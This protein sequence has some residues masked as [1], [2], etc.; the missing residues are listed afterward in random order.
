MKPLK[1]TVTFSG[2]D[3]PSIRHLRPQVL[4]VN[5]SAIRAKAGLL[6]GPFAASIGVPKGTLMNWEQGRR[7][8]TGA[9]KVLLAL[10]AKK[11]SLVAD[12]YPTPRQIP[13]WAAG[14]PDPSKMTAE[15]RLSELGQILAAGIL[16]V[17]ERPP[18]NL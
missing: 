2:S 13:R 14:G 1:V 18:G 3:D 17:R 12:L 5:V 6:Q 11:P 16:R 4:S 8:P 9:A 10:I 15:E 7:Q